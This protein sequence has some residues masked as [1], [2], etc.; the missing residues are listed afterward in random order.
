MRG[1]SHAVRCVKG[2]SKR[3][4]SAWYWWNCPS[5]RIALMHIIAAWVSVTIVT[6]VPQWWSYEPLSD[7]IWIIPMM[8]WKHLSSC[9]VAV[10]RDTEVAEVITSV[11]LHHLH[12]FLLFN[13]KAWWFMYGWPLGQCTT[14]AVC[15][16]T[17]PLHFVWRTFHMQHW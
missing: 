13:S 12:D 3:E 8:Q 16:N 11:R 6:K 17:L 7:W 1:K 14:A 15:K 4:Q 2:E 10:Q 9:R 5:N